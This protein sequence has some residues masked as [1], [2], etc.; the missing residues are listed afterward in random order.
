M[1]YQVVKFTENIKN[2]VL[3]P[4][5]VFTVFLLALGALKHRTA[6]QPVFCIAF[7]KYD[8]EAMI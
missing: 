4:P 5:A 7:Y 6:L 3:S 8:M 1:F 2:P